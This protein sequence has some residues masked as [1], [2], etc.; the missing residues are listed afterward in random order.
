MV[1]KNFKN[2]AKTLFL[3]SGQSI[4]TDFNLGNNF[5]IRSNSGAVFYVHGSFNSSYYPASAQMILSMN[6]G[7]SA[8]VALGSGT[9]PATE[10][11][12]ALESPITSGITGTLAIIKYAD[13]NAGN[14]MCII[15]VRNSTNAAITIG[16]I[17]MYQ[18]I[19]STSD[20]YSGSSG[21]V[22]LLDRTVLDP[23]IVLAAS[24]TKVIEYKLS[25]AV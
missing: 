8:G 25:A 15:T 11:D 24:E 17:G 22:C 23:P 4:S 12:Y 1:T 20:N 19:F 9:T 6:A 7:N 3:A 13:N 18:N 2:I 16:E 5:P 14:I 21:H 10:N